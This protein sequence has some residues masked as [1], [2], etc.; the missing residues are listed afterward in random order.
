M[1]YPPDYAHIVSKLYYSEKSLYN[2]E[3]SWVDKIFSVFDFA[4]TLHRHFGKI[5]YKQM[6]LRSAELMFKRTEKFIAK[7]CRTGKDSAA[8]YCFLTKV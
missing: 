8:R 1:A 7:L 3:K 5:K 4:V 2:P 6:K